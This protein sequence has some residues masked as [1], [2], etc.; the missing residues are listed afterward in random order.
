MSQN[1]SDGLLP[2]GVVLLNKLDTSYSEISNFITYLIQCM[3]EN[4]DDKGVYFYNK[5]T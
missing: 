4:N 1:G 2:F 5:I 3:I